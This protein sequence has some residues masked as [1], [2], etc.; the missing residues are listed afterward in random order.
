[1]LAYFCRDFEITPRLRRELLPSRPGAMMP[2]DYDENANACALHSHAHSPAAVAASMAIFF[3]AMPA[4]L[5]TAGAA[6]L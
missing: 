6:M 4:L 2:A 3:L 1:M 5:V